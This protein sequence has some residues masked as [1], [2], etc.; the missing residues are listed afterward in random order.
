[1]QQSHNLQR[2]YKAKYN[3]KAVYMLRACDSKWKGEYFNIH[4]QVKV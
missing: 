3:Q 1:M 4:F 2:M